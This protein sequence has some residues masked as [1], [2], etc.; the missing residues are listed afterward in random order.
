ME[1]EI[2]SFLAIDFIFGVGRADE[3]QDE[4]IDA[5]GGFDDVRNEF[6]FRFL[7]KVIERCK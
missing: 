3:R 6:F 5:E 2:V 1:G 7:V 4:T